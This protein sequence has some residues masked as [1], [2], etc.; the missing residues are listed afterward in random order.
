M[1]DVFHGGGDQR[2]VGGDYAGLLDIDMTGH[3][4]DAN[5]VAGVF[6]AGKS[7]D[8]VYVDQDLRL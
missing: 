1:G 5:G 8:A 6:Y 4:P 2:R 3:C 7:V